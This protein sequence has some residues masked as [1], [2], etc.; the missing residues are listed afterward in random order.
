MSFWN[1]WAKYVSFSSLPM[2]VGPG[3]FYALNVKKTINT[4]ALDSGVGSETEPDDSTERVEQ[5]IKTPC[6][7]LNLSFGL[8]SRCK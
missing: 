8:I 3:F 2:E 6:G 4:F 7:G 1:S 5:Q